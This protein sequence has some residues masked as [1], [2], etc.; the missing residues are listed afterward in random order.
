MEKERA[1]PSASFAVGWNV[2]VAPATAEVDGVPEIVGAR[3]VTG[4]FTWIENGARA[5]VDHPLVTLIVIFE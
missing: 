2:Y 5:A 3:F 1:S 4:G